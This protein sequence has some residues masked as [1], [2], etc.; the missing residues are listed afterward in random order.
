MEW[1]VEF[2]FPATATRR[3]LSVI[4][5]RRRRLIQFKLDIRMVSP[6]DLHGTVLL[7]FRHECVSLW[8]IAV[9]TNCLTN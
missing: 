4:R 5:R 1:Q 3:L 2:T 8:F 6:G 7:T 9:S